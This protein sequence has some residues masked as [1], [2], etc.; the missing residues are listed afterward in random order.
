MRATFLGDPGQGAQ[1]ARQILQQAMRRVHF[2]LAD[3]TEPSL[4]ARRIGGTRLC[5][6]FFLGIKKKD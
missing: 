3:G 2:T 1:W 4:V 5:S 6:W